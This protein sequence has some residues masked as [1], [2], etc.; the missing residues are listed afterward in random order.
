MMCTCRTMCFYVEQYHFWYLSGSWTR[1][2]C[3]K[4]GTLRALTAI[5]KSCEYEIKPPRRSWL[6]ST[7]LVCC[8]LAS[9]WINRSLFISNFFNNHASGFNNP[10]LLVCIQL[11][12]HGHERAAYTTL[13]GP[14]LVICNL[15]NYDIVRSAAK[16]WAKPESTVMFPVRSSNSSHCCEHPRTC[17]VNIS[18]AYIERHIKRS[19]LRVVLLSI[20]SWNISP[21]ILSELGMK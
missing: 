15:L 14:P 9:V 3:L 2:W 5:V 18:D 20:F 17:V 19:D 11:P 10:S 7:P 4:G 6:C 1:G 8:L 16:W 13:R 12:D 21:G